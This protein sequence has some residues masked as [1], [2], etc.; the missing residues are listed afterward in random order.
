MT[1]RV[2]FVNITRGRDFSTKINTKV[3]LR[4]MLSNSLIIIIM[5]LLFPTFQHENK[6]EV[7]IPI[8]K[9]VD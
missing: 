1:P 9:L 4:E 7:N 3:F 6:N 5:N 2:S 8:A